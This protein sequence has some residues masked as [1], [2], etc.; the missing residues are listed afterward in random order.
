VKR[1]GDGARAAPMLL[2]RDLA[3]L[4]R[5]LELTCKACGKTASYDVGV[6]FFDP[7]ARLETSIATQ[8]AVGFSAYLRCRACDGAGGWELP[9]G[10]VQALSALRASAAAGMPGVPAYFVRPQLFDGTVV[11]FAT[12]A[13]RHLKKLI[14]GDPENAKL[15]SRLGNLYRNAGRPDLA[16]R[17]CER[18]VELDPWDIET[19]H[20]L[21]E[22]ALERKEHR[23]AAEHFREVVNRAWRKKGE[24][25][26][27]D[28]RAYVRDTLERL[29]DIHEETRGRVPFLERCGGDLEPVG[30][31]VTLEIREFDLSGDSGWEGLV[32]MVLREPSL[33]RLSVGFQDDAE[34]DAFEPWID[35]GAGGPRWLR[36]QPLHSLLPATA[37]PRNAP[38]PCGSGRKYK[39]CCG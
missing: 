1:T 5:K 37:P 39:N 9:P 16:V 35:G 10:T 23:R 17:A 8:D 32:S 30:G 24:M 7:A 21:G 2:P 26:R 4:G 28:L 14:A 13:E 33:E 27:Q 12:D 19:H 31:T 22:L 34:E 29:L 3:P 18:A 25:R 15:R 38:C 20:T 6:V 36:R 11:R